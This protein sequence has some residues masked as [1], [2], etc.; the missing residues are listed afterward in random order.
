MFIYL[1]IC[2]DCKIL[3]LVYDKKQYDLQHDTFDCYCGLENYMVNFFYIP[4][5]DRDYNKKKVLKYIK[6]HYPKEQLKIIHIKKKKNFFTK[7]LYNI[8]K[9]IS[10]NV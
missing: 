8:Y 3:Y 1:Y 4:S 6:T 5:L 7:I 10:K 2:L 9:R